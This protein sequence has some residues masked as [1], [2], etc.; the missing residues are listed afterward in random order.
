MKKLALIAALMAV[1]GL[2]ADSK[3][4]HNEGCLGHS[5]T[6]IQ[7]NAKEALS[8]KELTATCKANCKE[9][10][11]MAA[12]CKKCECVK[13]HASK[14]ICVECHM[15]R[16]AFN[17]E[18]IKKCGACCDTC[19]DAAD[20]IEDLAEACEKD[21]KAN[22]SKDKAKKANAKKKTM[23]NKDKKGEPTKG[24]AGHANDDSMKN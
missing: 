4:K 13:K 23:K 18:E 11:K 22:C 17:A 6:R 21:C 2:Q 5:L 1:A 3:G 8:R 19:K 20:K 7:D 24:H 16:I 9:I 14:P 12:E 15:R 10:Q